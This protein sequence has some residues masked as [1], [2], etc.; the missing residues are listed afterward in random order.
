M[1]RV[2]QMLQYC[3]QRIVENGRANLLNVVLNLAEENHEVRARSL[4]AVRRMENRR[5]QGKVNVT[6]FLKGFFKETSYLAIKC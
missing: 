3:G 4:F 1:L 2:L 6:K 5:P